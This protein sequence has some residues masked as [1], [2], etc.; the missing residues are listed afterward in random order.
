MPKSS[1]YYCSTFWSN[2]KLWWIRLYSRIR[3]W[4]DNE[5]N[6]PLEWNQACL[7]PLH[8]I[9]YQKSN[10]VQNLIKWIGEKN[11]WISFN[12]DVKRNE[13]WESKGFYILLKMC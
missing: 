10:S 12:N 11:S 1:N 4:M 2:L 7:T 8:K 3:S 13:V 5:N 6:K 9:F